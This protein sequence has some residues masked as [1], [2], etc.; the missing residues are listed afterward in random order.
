MNATFDDG[1]FYRASFSGEE[2]LFAYAKFSDEFS[3]GGVKLSGANVSFYGA[4][5]AERIGAL[6][7]LA[8]RLATGVVRQIAHCCP[9]SDL[10]D[11]SGLGQQRQ[12]RLMIRGL[13]WWNCRDID[14]LVSAM[15][16]II[17]YAEAC[18][19]GD[20]QFSKVIANVGR[21]SHLCVDMFIKM[22]FSRIL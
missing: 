4:G 12:Y 21:A 2:V 16:A 1:D 18:R 11:S 14:A 17:T 10:M 3:F 5:A 15:K 22:M 20:A 8:D 9:R 19:S 13:N 6:P 7:D